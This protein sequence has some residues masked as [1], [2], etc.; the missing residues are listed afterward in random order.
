MVS[1]LH[2]SVICIR[3]SEVMALFETDSVNNTGL[4]NTKPED[5]GKVKDLANTSVLF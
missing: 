2:K 5:P 4:S 1:V 3:S